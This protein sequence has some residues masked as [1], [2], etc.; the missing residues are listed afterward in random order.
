[1]TQTMRVRIVTA[2]FMAVLLTA[3]AATPMLSH[4]TGF[5]GAAHAEDCAGSSC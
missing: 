4:I 3:S 5:G 1:M 2:V